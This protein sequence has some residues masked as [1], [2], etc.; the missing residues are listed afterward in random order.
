M[1]ELQ[2]TSKSNY[3]ISENCLCDFRMI[4]IKNRYSPC[5]IYRGS[6]PRPYIQLNLFPW[7]LSQSYQYSK[8]KNYDASDV[9]GNG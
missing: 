1:M 4:K 3:L 8:I 6:N 2:N 9:V 5:S 7:P